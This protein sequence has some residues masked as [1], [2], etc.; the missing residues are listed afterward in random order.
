MEAPVVMVWMVALTVLKAMLVFLG[1]LLESGG[2]V[3]AYA[4]GEA[5][6]LLG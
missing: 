5:C 6:F 2:H 1:V 4:G 3:G